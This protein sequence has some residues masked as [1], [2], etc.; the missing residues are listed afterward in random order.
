MGRGKTIE[1][2]VFR[3]P[4]DPG[5][6]PD[7][8]TG[9]PL[10][11]SLFAWNVRSGLSA[12]RA[13]LADEARYADYW[14]WPSA[15]RLLRRAD[16]LGF[17]HQVQYGMWGGFGGA[18]RWNDE[19][20]DFATAAA[21]SAAVTRNLNLFSTVH[22]GYGFHPMHIA[23]I[24]ACIDVVSGGPLG[25]QRR[26]GR[27]S[28]RLPQVRRDRTAV[29][30][31]ALRHGRRVRHPDE[32]PVGVRRPR[33]LRGRTLQVLRRLRR[34]QAG[35]Q[36]PSRPDERGP[37]G[38]RFRL[39]LP[40]GG[41]GVRRAAQGTPRGLRGHGAQGPR[42]GRRVRQAGARRRHVLRHRRGDGRRGRAHGGLA[43]ERGPTTTRFCTTRAP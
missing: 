23:K 32:I 41:L 34:P 2:D 21:A 7:A 8:A 17:D 28:G 9:Q 20:L 30:S 38:R 43:G 11:I 37:V 12:T 31:R 13:V 1:A 29:G 35:A 39:R 25:A 22:V 14:R 4:F 6:Q 15:E 10:E 19:G 27:Q 42:A 36:A 5:G 26:V 18:S 24:G 3:G 33:R 40:P 16:A